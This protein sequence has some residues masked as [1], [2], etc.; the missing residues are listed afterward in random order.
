MIPRETIQK[1][2]DTARIEEVVGDFVQLKRVRAD[3]WACC[4]FHGEKTPSFH[5]VPSRGIYYCFGCHK[6]GSAVGFVM[7][8]ERLTY[9]EALRYLARKYHIE[10]VEKEETP[11]DKLHNE[12]KE[13]LYAVSEYAKTFFQKQL[14][15]SEE[16]RSIGLAYFHSRGLEDETISKY[17]LGWAPRGS[18]YNR[19]TFTEQALSAGYKADYLVETGLSADANAGRE[20]GQQETPAVDPKALRDRFYERVVFPIQSLSGRVMAFG[21]RTLKSKEEGKPYAKYVNSKES[22]IYL[23]NKTLYGI[24]FARGEI[25]KQDKCYLVEGY[26]DVLS[27]H[28]LGITNVVASC[29]TALTEDQ[30]A[31]FRRFTSNVTIMYDGDDAGVH[32]T[33]RAMD[34]CL[35]AGMNVRVVIFPD[36]HDPDSYSRTHSKEE[37][38]TFL[39]EAEQD[40]VAFKA[41]RQLQ[42][43]EKDPLR[44]AEAINA[45]AD[46]VA[47]I[48]DPI[49]RGT[50]IDYL[51][52]TYDVR[53]E[54]LERRVRNTRKKL[55]EEKRKAESYS[56]ATRQR[57]EV[58]GQEYSGGTAGAE[59]SGL[60]SLETNKVM[61]TAEKDILNLVLIYGTT[62]L[63]FPSDSEFYS[64]EPQT[65]FGFIDSALAADEAVFANE[66]YKAVYDAYS[67]EYYQNLSQEDIVRH[68][69]DS[70]DRQLAYIVS[71]LSVKEPYD[72]SVKNLR[73]SMTAEVTWLN[74]FVPKSILVFNLARLE[75]LN[76]ELKERLDNASTD[77][78]AMEVMDQVKRVKK[79]L[80]RI[81][82]KLGREQKRD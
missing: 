64:D 35:D 72:L 49:K 26:L 62:P 43:T 56:A 73:E 63:V 52:R 36:D 24:S 39:R 44:R 80:M 54:A 12:H 15:E 50:Y 9:P 33:L 71:Q 47:I 46:T 78:E 13:S 28:Q 8:H 22:L 69:L 61:G 31:L 14:T 30:I 6:S 2:L 40:C 17:G 32:A 58:A 27:M 10:I 75:T 82:R 70:E 34:M 51:S 3:Y 42:G 21:A 25:A 81:K 37:V 48:P 19:R 65:V 38:E 67:D 74:T 79:N 11:E 4:P 5:V 77:E 23:K 20:N 66:C 76:K 16:G 7:E 60:A 1:I 53:A 55:V 41:E 59:V 29:G 45:V 68:L 18:S 57:T